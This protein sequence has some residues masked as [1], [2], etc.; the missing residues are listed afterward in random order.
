[1]QMLFPAMDGII[2][3]TDLYKIISAYIKI[4]KIR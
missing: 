2:I 1:M 3:L 4:L